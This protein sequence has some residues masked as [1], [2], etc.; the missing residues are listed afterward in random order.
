MKRL[1][2]SLLLLMF[3]L[4]SSAVTYHYMVKEVDG[5]K[6]P[7]RTKTLHVCTEC[8]Y[9]TIESALAT[10]NDATSTNLYIIELHSGV[11]AESPLTWKSFVYLRGDGQDS[12]KVYCSGTCSTITIG[13]LDD[14]GFQDVTIGGR[15]PINV[16]GTGAAGAVVEFESVTLGHT[17]ASLGT[18]AVDCIVESG[19]S[20]TY[21]FNNSVCR[22]TF[23]SIRLNQN[24]TFRAVGSVFHTVSVTNGALVTPRVFSTVGTGGSFYLT[25]VQVFMTDTGTSGNMSG[26]IVQ[27]TGTPGAAETY[28]LEDVA[29]FI[30]ESSSRTGTT[31][32]VYFAQA[33][34]GS[35][36]VPVKLKNVTCQI[37]RQSSSG[38]VV[39]LEID[40]SNH[41]LWTIDVIGGMSNLDVCSAAK[42][43]ASSA[44]CAC[45]TG[46]GTGCGFTRNDIDNA[47][48]VAGF[49][50]NVHDFSTGGV[51][52]GT[53]PTFYNSPIR[54]GQIKLTPIA[55]APATC[56]IGDYYADTSGAFCSCSAAN[57]WTNMNGV[58]AC[59]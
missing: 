10:I 55:T 2:L 6:V 48:T 13:S 47:E 33:G 35:V 24:S 1:I 50:L 58:G 32:C 57:T 41:A 22:T 51:F 17:D 37:K 29:F 46:A 14:C 42:C 15:V 9:T 8:Q 27:G 49:S 56:T 52:V 3:T 19:A 31:R 5:L 45:C 36:P 25:A 43:T 16:T 12:T 59:V 39:A 28:L 26:L 53:A 30:D 7:L 18:N 34:S 23:D 38:T 40:A 11:Y 54:G 44:P 21:E 20:Y 4:P